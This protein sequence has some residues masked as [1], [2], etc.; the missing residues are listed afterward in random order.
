M[1]TPDQRSSVATHTLRDKLVRFQRIRAEAG[2]FGLAIDEVDDRRPWGGF[3]KF[4]HGSV[5][6]F[7]EAYWGT[8]LTDYW[9]DML[10]DYAKRARVATPP[11][12]LDAKLLLVAPG[13]RLSLQSHARRSELWRV[14][15]G[16]VVVVTGSTEENVADRQVK[17]GEVVR[18]QNGHLHRLAAPHSGWG[19][20]AEIWLHE[21]AANPSDEYDIQRYDDDY[22]MV[23][24]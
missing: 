4:T 7:L 8:F 18:I 2:G 9:R 3:V 17:P 19:V 20:I 11:L 16:P 12:Q 24:R 5:D 6:R 21:D 23:E 14:L 1:S 10:A 15:E 22:W 13:E